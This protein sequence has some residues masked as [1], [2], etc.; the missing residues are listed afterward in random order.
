M[1][2]RDWTTV[3]QIKSLDRAS[4]Y[5]SVSEDIASNK[6]LTFCCEGWIHFWVTANGSVEAIET[7]EGTWTASQHTQSPSPSPA[8][9]S[10]FLMLERLR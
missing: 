10:F 4:A 3:D 9:D 7:A 6:Q 5:A 2:S 1:L 8:R